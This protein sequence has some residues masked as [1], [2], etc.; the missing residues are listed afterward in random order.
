VL[1]KLTVNTAQHTQL[2]NVTG[3]VRKAV[4]ESGVR[5]GIC[6]VFVPH[7][8]AGVTINENADPDVVRDLISSLEK[9]VPWED[10]YRHAEGN[11]AAH[12]KA[13]MMGFSQQLIVDGGELLLGTW[14][15]IWFCEFDGPR[16]RSLVVKVTEG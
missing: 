6:T 13:S 5:E 9:L 3:L 12:L 1:K 10:G 11:S 16:R 14:Q 8:T 15:G 2:V 7:T 4:E